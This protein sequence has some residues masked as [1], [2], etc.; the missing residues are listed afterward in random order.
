MKFIFLVM[1]LPQLIWAEPGQ[2]KPVPIHS[3]IILADRFLNARGL[4]DFEVQT[5]HYNRVACAR[6]LFSQSGK[7]IEGDA[8]IKATSVASDMIEVEFPMY[9]NFTS[10]NSVSPFRNEV[11]SLETMT[12][13]RLIKTHPWVGERSLIITKQL[14]LRYEKSESQLVSSTAEVRVMEESYP[15]TF[16]IKETVMAAKPFSVYFICQ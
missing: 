12:G 6:R 14:K 8:D 2:L 9:V 16:I 5:L 1:F 15:S 7:S 3:G 11:E 13:R 10:F 4:K